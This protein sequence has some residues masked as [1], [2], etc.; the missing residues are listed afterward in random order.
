M[1]GM[2]RRKEADL[3]VSQRRLISE[4]AAAEGRKGFSVRAAVQ[5][6]L[7]TRGQSE[8][9]LAEWVLM[10]LVKE[11]KRQRPLALH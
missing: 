8:G 1:P 3:A 2:L 10:R 4:G 9:S 5:A 6:V 11:M 7:I